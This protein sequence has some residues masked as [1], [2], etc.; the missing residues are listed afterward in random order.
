[1][2]GPAELLRLLEER[3]QSSAKELAETTGT[4]PERVGGLLGRLLQARRVVREEIPGRG[5]VWSS[6][7]PRRRRRDEV[8]R[9]DD[10]DRMM[11][12]NRNTM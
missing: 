3:P 2:T 11:R 1:V 4:S 10:L 5:V 9:F 7:V 6:T 12:T 8:D